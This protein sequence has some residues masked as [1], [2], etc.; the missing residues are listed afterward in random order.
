MFL[1]SVL[2]FLL[3]PRR[4]K[5]SR[6]KYLFKRYK[7]GERGTCCKLRIYPGEKAAFGT[8]TQLVHKGENESELKEVLDL[9]H[10][11]NLPMTF[12]EFGIEDEQEGKMKKPPKQPAYLRS[13]PKTSVPTYL[14][15]KF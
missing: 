14:S 13:I 4:S 5:H 6:G 2:R 1:E 9:I 7:P 12:K 3:T 8:L 10:T 15:K 11:A